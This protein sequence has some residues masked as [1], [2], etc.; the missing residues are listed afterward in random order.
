MDA[1]LQALIDKIRKAAERGRPLRIRGGGSKDFYGQQLQGE[2]LDTR[3]LAG[4]VAYEPS[5]LV[6]TARAGT[7]LRDLQAL[8]ACQ[9]NR[10]V[11]DVYF[12]GTKP[13]PL[14]RMRIQARHPNAGSTPQYGGQG[15]V[16]NA[17]CLQ[18][19]VNGDRLYGV[20]Q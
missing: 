5:E 16:G 2:L 13:P 11:N 15:L 7:R 19:T 4:I 10:G 6:V 14:A 12:F 3:P 8:L 20:A 18:D 17:Q 1:A 9:V